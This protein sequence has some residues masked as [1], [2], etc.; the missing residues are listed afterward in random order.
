MFCTAGFT[1][2][3]RSNFRCV[4]LERNRSSNIG[5]PYANVGATLPT[6]SSAQRGDG[7]IILHKAAPCA[8]ALSQPPLQ[9]SRRALRHAAGADP[10]LDLWLTINPHWKSEW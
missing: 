2:G 8:R 5:R 3:R 9:S 4:W 1:S 10:T 7:F 6:G